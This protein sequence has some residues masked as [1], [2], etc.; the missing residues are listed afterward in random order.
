M[1]GITVRGLVTAG[2]GGGEAGRG[3]VPSGIGLTAESPAPG[4][5][6]GLGDAV[7]AGDSVMPAGGAAVG[8]AISG[9]GCA[10]VAIA[11][12]D[13]VAGPETDKTGGGTGV[14]PDTTG[15]W[16]FAGSVNRASVRRGATGGTDSGGA[17]V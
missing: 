9:A 14:C 6:C 10:G 7:G 11:G 5:G 12:A 8:A 16:D 15:P 17:V 1:S 13:G 2:S 4:C 3:I